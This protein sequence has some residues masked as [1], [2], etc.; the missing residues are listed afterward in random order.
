MNRREVIHAGLS[1]GLA[2]LAPKDSFAKAVSGQIIEY[3]G[4]SARG[5]PPQRLSIWLPPDY[6]HSDKR[7]KVLYMHDA[8]NL[9]IPAYSNFNKVWAADAAMLEFAQETN[10]DPWVIVGI[11]SPGED[12]Y[13][14]YLPLPAYE[15]STGQ[16]RSEMDAYAKGEI[17][18]HLYL[19]WIVEK[20]KPWVDS[21]FRTK[22]NILDTA[23]IGSSMGGLISLYAFLRHSD[24][25][26]RAGC[27]STHWPAVAP[28]NVEDPNNEMM[29]IWASIIRKGIDAK[30]PNGRQIWF[31]HGTA[32]LDASYPPYQRAID[33]LFEKT[34]WQRGRNWMSKV[35]PGAEHEENAWAKRLPEVFGWLLAD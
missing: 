11:W 13:R 19:D 18:S 30:N 23:I 32:T 26:G 6:A 10:L 14:Q 25:F 28:Q 34:A 20:L 24:V 22:S 12:R 15:A 29:E 8:Q 3:S 21:S 2:A 5:L 35:Y 9:F 27:V 16:L 1:L 17:V 33:A 4:I 7:Y 31:D